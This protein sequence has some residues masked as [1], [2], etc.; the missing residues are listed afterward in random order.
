MP[1]LKGIRSCLA[2]ISD[3]V[4][5]ARSSPLNI[6]LTWQTQEATHGVVSTATALI[7]VA[8]GLCIGLIRWLRSHLIITNSLN[9]SCIHD[10][11][12]GHCS[13]Q[14]NDL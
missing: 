7:A 10:R 12:A 1:C 9:T 2:T 11:S 4:P 3:L 5:D 6:N 14:T 8:L 13:I